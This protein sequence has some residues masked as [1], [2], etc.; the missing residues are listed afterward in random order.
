MS[1]TQ[2]ESDLTPHVVT[3]GTAGGP[4]WW[5]GPSQGERA[6]I[7][8]AVVVGEAVYVVDV[9]HGVGRNLMLA[10]LDIPRI[11]GIF[12]T[13]LHSDHTV[14]LAGM[15]V[16]GFMNITDPG[17][18]PI[19][20]LGPGNRGVL[21]PVSPRAVRSPD[22]LFPD[23][24]TLGTQEMVSTLLH[25]YSTD[26]NDRVLDALRPS[27]LEFFRAEDIV[28][29]N[30]TGFHPND[31]PTPVMEPF[32]IYRDD[33]VIVTATLVQHPP[34]A[35]AFAFRFDTAH[36]SVTISGDTAPCD[37]LVRL[38]R[39]TDLLLHEAIDF[40]WV[41]QAYAHEQSNVAQASID[42]HHKSHTS[43][44]QAGE[45]ASRAGARALALH[46]LVPGTADPQVWRAAENT[47]TGPV[48]VPNDLDIIPFTHSGYSVAALAEQA[49]R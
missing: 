13:H 43:P 21:P 24:P 29:P 32:Q 49:T 12:L 46:H 7:A 37:N 36:G 47:F 4:R 35:P 42:H 39:D 34:I 6:G 23:N 14:D 9:G 26:I 40:D 28:V 17:Q 45:I 5:K 31:N 25:A 2:S 8:T 1:V 27:P 22:P 33:L 30:E 44:E 41:R 3:L 48:H 16:F 19:R 20:I 18:R 15:T 38:A 11:R 10:G